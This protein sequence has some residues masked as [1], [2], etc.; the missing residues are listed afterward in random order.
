MQDFADAPNT[1]D[2]KLE[3]VVARERYIWLRNKL[4]GLKAAANPDAAAIDVVI[5]DL[6]QAQ[7]AYKATHGIFGNNPFAEESKT[8]AQTGDVGQRPAV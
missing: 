4:L 1:N 7:L 2:H 3:Q 6:E 5:R 8:Q